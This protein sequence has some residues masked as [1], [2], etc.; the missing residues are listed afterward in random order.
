MR[1]PITLRV[2]EATT[3]I[4]YVYDEA[5][6]LATTPVYK[7]DLADDGTLEI[8]DLEL[9][10]PTSFLGATSYAGVPEDDGYGHRAVVEIG[11]TPR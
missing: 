6:I 2:T 9:Q 1:E 4:E 5:T 11:G 8:G 7:E 3:A 10:V